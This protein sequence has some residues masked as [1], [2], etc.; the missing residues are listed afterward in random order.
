MAST[1]PLCQIPHLIPYFTPIPLQF[2][3]ETAT[4]AFIRL[5]IT[6]R[7]VFPSDGAL[8]LEDEWNRYV[9]KLRDDL[10]AAGGR[11]QGG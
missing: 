11:G 1:L 9:K 7:R 3:E 5:S 4:V 6:E 10:Q 2:Y 8:S